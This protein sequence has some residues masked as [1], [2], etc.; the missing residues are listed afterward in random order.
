VPTR[1]FDDWTVL[2]TRGAGVRRIADL[3]A[4]GESHRIRG[5][6]HTTAAET[7]AEILVARHLTSSTLLPQ[8]VPHHV[9]PSAVASVVGAIG[10]GPHGAAVAA[11]SARLASV[12][13]VPGRLVAASTSTDRDS[14]AAVA[15]DRSAN[16][17]PG[18]DRS[19][20]RVSDVTDVV[21]TMPRTPCS[22]SVLPAAPGSSA[23]SRGR[24][25]S[26]L[27]VL[28]EVCSWY[29]MRRCGASGDSMT[30]GRSGPR[31][32]STMCCGC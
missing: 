14:A 27:S 3:L 23:I 1:P 13:G 31:C 6:L 20:R 28:R 9:D 4:T 19:V 17:A 10:T 21:R 7:G 22:C 8:V 29:A 25:A 18:L 2:H 30:G 15:L 16:A 26:S 24:A 5:D 11:V 12:L 32:G